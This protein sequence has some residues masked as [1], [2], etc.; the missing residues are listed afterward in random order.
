[1]TPNRTIPIPILDSDSESEVE[2]K[3]TLKTAAKT[4]FAGFL[5]RAVPLILVI[6]RTPPRPTQNLPMT[7]RKPKQRLQRLERFYRH[8]SFNEH[9]VRRN[10]NSEEEGCG[11]F[12]QLGPSPPEPQLKKK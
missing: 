8:N 10:Q 4:P 5:M 3:E 11:R 9:K 6:P 12:L 7:K 1:M 2:R